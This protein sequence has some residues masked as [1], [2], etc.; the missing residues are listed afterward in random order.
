MKN[1]DEIFKE[2]D[3]DGVPWQQTF[4]WNQIKAVLIEMNKEIEELKN[5]NPEEL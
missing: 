4:L 3:E 5:G 2:I 1:I